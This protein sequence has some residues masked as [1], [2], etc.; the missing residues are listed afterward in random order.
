MPK[1]RACHTYEACPPCNTSEPNGPCDWLTGIPSDAVCRAVAEQ[2]AEGM[3]GQGGLLGCVFGVPVPCARLQ[4]V[5]LQFF[6]ARL[7][8]GCLV[9]KTPQRCTIECLFRQP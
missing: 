1:A 9:V 6:V 2:G 4:D 5:P 7:V 3:A 8:L